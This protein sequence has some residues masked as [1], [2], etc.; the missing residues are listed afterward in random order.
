MEILRNRKRSLELDRTVLLLRAMNRFFD[1]VEYIGPMR[2]PPSRTYL[3][4]GERRR[5]IGAAG[6]NTS[7]ILAMDSAR[8]GERSLNILDKVSKWLFKAEIAA[9]IKIADI[10]DRHFEIKVQHPNTQEYQNIADVGQGNSQIL[11]VLVAG[12]N[13]TRGSTYLVEEPEIHLHPRAQAE[14]GDFF[15][16]LYSSG[17]QSVIETHSEYLVVRLQ[18]H[19]VQ[20]I[21][22][23]EDIAVYYVYPR[24]N[25]KIIKKLNLNK[26]GVFEEE[27]PEG[28]FP[29]RLSEA[30]KLAMLREK[31]R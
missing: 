27:W 9:N 10:S 5:R 21:I 19:V 15:Y 11:P 7:S 31:N 13:L 24:E 28:F 3:F 18:Q 30:K 6:E 12:Y 14:L 20:G 16:D 4:S 26:Q 1:S 22:D 2:M 8:E 23:P 25:K 29:E 17:I